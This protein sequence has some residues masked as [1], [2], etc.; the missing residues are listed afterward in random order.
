VAGVYG[1]NFDQMP[2]LHWDLGYP[3]AIGLMAATAGLMY[4]IFKKKGWL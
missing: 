1:M 3:M 4:A 2:E